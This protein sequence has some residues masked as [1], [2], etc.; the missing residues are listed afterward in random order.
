MSQ[1]VK[2]CLE[3][4]KKLLAFFRYGVDYSTDPS[5][6][7]NDFNK[8]IANLNLKLI[9]FDDL[10]NEMKSLN[11]LI[12]KLIEKNNHDLA[13]ENPIHLG[14]IQDPIHSGLNELIDSNTE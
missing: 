8:K 14:L 1:I 6:V 2:S 3:D 13:I 12:S 4:K 9:P 10:K 11:K 5:K 7:I